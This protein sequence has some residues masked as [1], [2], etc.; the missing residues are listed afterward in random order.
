MTKF[1]PRLLEHPFIKACSQNNYSKA[2]YLLKY[3]IPQR[4]LDEALESVVEHQHEDMVDLL[5][6][7]GANPNAFC[8][9]SLKLAAQ[10]GNRTIMIRLLQEGADPKEAFYSDMEA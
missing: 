5:I 1:N 2:R 9:E 6:L 3:D 4:L 7:H 8:A 10:A